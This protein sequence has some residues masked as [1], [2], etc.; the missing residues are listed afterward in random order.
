MILNGFNS[1]NLLKKTKNGLQSI[2]VGPATYNN[3][4]TVSVLAGWVA[5][6]DGTNTNIY[7]RDGQTWQASLNKIYSAECDSVSYGKDI[8]GNKIWVGVGTASVQVAYSTNNG[9]TWAAGTPSTVFGT[10][11]RDVVYGQD[12][13]GNPMWVGAGASNGCFYSTNGINWTASTAPVTV[14]RGV[15]FGNNQ[16]LLL[17]NN[18]IT[19]STNYGQSWSNVTTTLSQGRD[20]AYGIDINGIGRWVGVGTGTGIIATST[21]GTNW[22]PI[23]GASNHVTQGYTVAYGNDT[24]GNYRWVIGGSGGKKLCYTNDC[25][26]FTACNGISNITLVNGVTCGIESNGTPLWIAV[27]QGTENILKSVDGITWTSITDK[28]NLLTSTG[29][30]VC[31]GQ[32]LYNKPTYLSYTVGSNILKGSINGVTYITLFSPFSVAINTLVWNGSLWVGGGE[33]ENTLASSVNGVLWNGK[34][35]TV[36]SIKCT[37]VE[38]NS[39]ELKWYAYGSGTNTAAYSTDGINWTPF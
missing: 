34:G 28:T 30:G 10:Y 5:G 29:Y 1:L 9:N 26:T 31:C 18:G 17:G 8:N 14:Y 19:L 24:N 22:T 2:I 25:I 21:D 39:A 35:T 7:S 20:A 15:A 6:G 38:W 13:N 12:A 36:F 3:P 33:G 23:T 32:D 37:L 11:G 16:Y 4:Q 27:G